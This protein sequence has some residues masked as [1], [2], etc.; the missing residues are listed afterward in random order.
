MLSIETRTRYPSGQCRLDG[1]LQAAEE[2]AP[3]SAISQI[4]GTDRRWGAALIDQLLHHNPSRKLPGWR[5]GEMKSLHSMLSCHDMWSRRGA[6]RNGPELFALLCCIAIMTSFRL[7][8][9]TSSWMQECALL[10]L[11]SRQW[12]NDSVKKRTSGV[13]VLLVPRCPCR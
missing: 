12:S 4:I 11:I 1:V 10:G 9:A 13:L 8:Q 3:Q 5:M 7:P 2:P 6:R